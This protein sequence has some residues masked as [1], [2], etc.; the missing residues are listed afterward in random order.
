MANEFKVK[1]GLIVNGTA[2]AGA[3][4]VDGALTDYAT[5]TTTAT[6]QVALASFAASSYGCGEFLI[7]ATQGTA[8]HITKILVAHDGTTAIATEYGSL[9]TGSILYSVDV[10]ISG[11]NVRVLIAPASAT[12]TVF[13]TTYTLIGA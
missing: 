2:T 11:G 7:Q 8:R 6:T 10:D 13:K 1:H 9:M 12:S 3:L 4:V 5:T